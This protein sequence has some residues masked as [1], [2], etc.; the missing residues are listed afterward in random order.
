ML[1][2]QLTGKLTKEKEIR[3]VIYHYHQKKAAPNPIVKKDE[4]CFI[5]LIVFFI[6][7]LLHQ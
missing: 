5:E 2:Y 4:Y 6:P 3:N 1:N 7:Q